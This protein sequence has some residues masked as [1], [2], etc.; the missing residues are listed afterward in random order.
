MCLECSQASKNMRCML[1]DWMWLEQK[2]MKGKHVPLAS[3]W[4]ELQGAEVSRDPESHPEVT[5]LQRLFPSK[6]VH[7]SGGE[8]VRCADVPWMKRRAWKRHGTKGSQGIFFSFFPS[9]SNGRKK[10]WN[11]RERMKWQKWTMK[12]DFLFLSNSRINRL[13]TY[14]LVALR[15]RAGT[16][17]GVP[18]PSF[19]LSST[20]Q[21]R[22]LRDS[23][24]AEVGK[25]FCSYIFIQ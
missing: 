10:S 7:R 12:K 16:G 4:Q 20:Y 2:V 22:L 21:E 8:P 11:F 15:K 6:A 14:L 19:A 13:R 1:R 9:W 23:V 24:D 18:A 3:S 17:A 25:S 5:N